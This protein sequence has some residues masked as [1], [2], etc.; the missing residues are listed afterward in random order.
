[1][2][3]VFKMACKWMLQVK[4]LTSILLS[5]RLFVFVCPTEA[6][7]TEWFDRDDERGSGDWEKLT[8]LREAYP[9]RLCNSPLDIQ[10]NVVHSTSIQYAQL[11][12]K[13]YCNL[14]LR[15]H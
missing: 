2:N 10:V 4:N 3:K 1:M 15:D 14:K 5:I 12:G 8:E 6:E 13:V 11:L 7:W 9:D